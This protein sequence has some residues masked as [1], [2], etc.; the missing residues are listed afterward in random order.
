MP[1]LD[2]DAKYVD[3]IKD[4][5]GRFLPDAEVFVYGSRTQGKALAY[6]DVDIALKSSE[7]IPIEKVLRL[8]AYFENSTFPYKV[9][10]IELNNIK[11]S[12]Y[13]IIKDDL[14]RIN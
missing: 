6:S 12:F 9:D 2:L 13:R 8:K 14:Y 11:E 10:V 1:K 5:A 4:A 7:K 3:F